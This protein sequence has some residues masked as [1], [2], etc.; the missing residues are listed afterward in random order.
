MRKN[1]F[2]TIHFFAMMIPMVLLFAASCSPTQSTV[3]ERL[4]V[5]YLENPL[6]IDLQKPRFSWIIESDQRDVV[7]TAYQIIVVDKKK[8]FENANNIVWDSG[9]IDDHGAVL[10]EYDGKPLESNKNYFWRV[11][12]WL[13][14]DTFIVSE[15]AQFTTGILNKDEWQADWIT[16][17]EEIVHESPYLRKE[18]EVKKKIEQALL[19]VT[20]TGFYNLYLNGSKVGDHILDPGIT[21]YRK[22][23]LY[24]TYDVTSE[25]KKKKNAIGVILGNG[26]WNMRKVNDR[27]SWHSAKSLGNPALFMQLVI[28]HSDGSTTVICSDESWKIDSGPITY[29]SLYGGEDYDAGKEMPGWGSTGFDDSQWHSVAVIDGPGGKLKSQLMPPMKITETITPIASI[30]PSPGVF[31]YDLG[32]NI[33]GAWRMEVK[34]EPGQ[35]IKIRGAETLS[36]SLYPKQLEESDRISTKFQ[37]S[38][39]TFTNYTL[40][41]GGVET[42]EPSFFYTGFRYIE[43]VTND[44]INP[45]HLKIEGRVVG[46]ALERNG[47]F[48]SSNQLLNQIHTVGLWSQRGN[49][50]SYPTDCPHREKGAYNGDGQLI[51]ETSMHDFH[52]APFY[53]KWVNDMKDA[54]QENGR[55]PNTSP[56]LVGGMGGGVGW[57]SA[58][59][60]VPWWMYNYYNDTRILEEHYPHMKEYV[61]YLKELGTKDE[62]PKEPYIIDFFDG[63][64][65]SLGEW[66]APNQREC[67]IRGVVNTF[68]Y[69]N[70]CLLLSE[71]ASKL[72]YNEDAIEYKNLSDTIKENYIRRYFNPETGLFGTDEPYMTY[73]V[74]ALTG[75]LIPEGYREKVF[76]TVTDD[77]RSRGTHLNT[78]IIGTK[79]LW[80]TLVQGGENQLAYE[81][82]TQTTFPSYGFWIKNGSTTF[83]ENWDVRASHNHQMFG[84][85][86]EYFYKFLGGIQSPM[87]G[88]TAVG[89]KD[90]FIKPYLPDGLEAVSTTIGTVSGDIVS[91]W[92]KEGSSFIQEVTVPAN[93]TATLSLPISSNDP[94][95]SESNQVIWDQNRFIEGVSGIHE[96]KMEEQRMMIRLG[97]GNYKFK[98]E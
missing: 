46:S 7:Q 36:D 90:I 87:E 68:Y 16:A 39:N 32:Q 85:V 98:V 77:I 28:K 40:K 73:Q 9:V 2:F 35:V 59:I 47:T 74:V 27:W 41:G 93:S 86:T 14:S 29:N 64:W 20:A 67:P 63:F 42:Y 57:G 33:A 88:K 78:G 4:T 91:N 95:I 3:V 11:K 58:Y 92:S 81:V 56:V 75:N 44:S 51:A 79:Y 45:E 60:L 55:I 61:A 83:L 25:I 17:K 84:T 71:I 15:A 5:E 69:Y 96:I 12:V 80:P 89:Y 65:Y 94:K 38:A 72:G 48:V 13:D 23:A 76:K 30:N 62:D 22:T 52:M 50:H 34:G 31:L 26:A 49:L 37:F 82:A 66:C 54:Q 21:D 8:S 24:S 1:N 10:I 53:T 6:G 97:S 70:N 43:V 19:Y 18:F